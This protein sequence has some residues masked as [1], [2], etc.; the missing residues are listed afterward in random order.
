MKW[1]VQVCLE[2]KMIFFKKKITTWLE[3][4]NWMTQGSPAMAQAVLEEK[5]KEKHGCGRGS[6]SRPSP[7][8]ALH[9]RIPTRTPPCA[10]GRRLLDVHDRARGATG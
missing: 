4:W 10:A 2:I 3:I 8:S 9:Q 6:V 5:T 7:T 1:H